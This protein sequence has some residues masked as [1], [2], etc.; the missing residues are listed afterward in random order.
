MIA[1]T[2]AVLA[3]LHGIPLDRDIVQ[4]A[5]SRP[6]ERCIP[7]EVYSREVESCDKP[8]DVIC[9]PVNQ[10]DF[11][12]EICMTRAQAVRACGK[13]WSPTGDKRCSR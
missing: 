1:S 2:L 6:L 11:R 12:D 7:K 8:G 4:R 3:F 9:I 5:Q 10:R 13:N